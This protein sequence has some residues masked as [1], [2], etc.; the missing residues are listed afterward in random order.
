MRRGRNNRLLVRPILEKVF[1]DGP[2]SYELSYGLPG[3]DQLE[4]KNYSER[5]IHGTG[6]NFYQRQFYENIVKKSRKIAGR[7]R[8]S[9][10]ENQYNE[11]VLLKNYSNIGGS[12]KKSKNCSTMD[13]ILEDQPHL[14]E[15]AR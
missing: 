10:G 3:Q 9:L 11:Q 15:Y 12:R 7:N 8:K 4:N 1:E 13:L 5:R 2:G 14:R 6:H